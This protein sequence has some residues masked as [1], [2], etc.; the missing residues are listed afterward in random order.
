V[1]PLGLRVVRPRVAADTQL[2]GVDTQPGEIVERLATRLAAQRHRE[3]THVHAVR[4]T[5]HTE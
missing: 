4:I 2:D 5:Q 1:E 3:Y